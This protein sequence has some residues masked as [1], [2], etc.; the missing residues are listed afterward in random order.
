LSLVSLDSYLVLAMLVVGI[1]TDCMEWTGVFMQVT[2]SN[3][4]D[5][6]FE[7]KNFRQTMAVTHFKI[8]QCNLLSVKTAQTCILV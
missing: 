8:C 1:L 6:V 7:T 3:H 2:T 4:G 5:G